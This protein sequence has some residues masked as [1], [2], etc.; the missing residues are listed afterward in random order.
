MLW[1]CL[2]FK[3]FLNFLNTTF[4]FFNDFYKSGMNFLVG[5]NG[6]VKGVGGRGAVKLVGKLQW[7]P[8]LFPHIW[9]P[10]KHKIKINHNNNLRW[11]GWSDKST[12]RQRRVCRFMTWKWSRY[13]S[14]RLGLVFFFLKAFSV[15]TT[16]KN[17]FEFCSSH[18]SSQKNG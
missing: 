16:W 6:D 4:D 18:L 5:M 10:R 9:S 12:K 14:L 11:C 13:I 2:I 3:F 17:W 1:C 15:L 8:L 7:N